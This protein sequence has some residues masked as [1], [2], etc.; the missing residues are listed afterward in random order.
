MIAWIAR[1][2]GNLPISAHLAC[3]NRQNG[4]LERVI[5]FPIFVPPTT[6]RAL[7]VKQVVDAHTH[8]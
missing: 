7:S 2:V 4:I 6:A 1:R 3:R 8:P 5:S